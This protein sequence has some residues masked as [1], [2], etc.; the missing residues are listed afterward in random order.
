MR[1]NGK[2]YVLRTPVK[3]ALGVLIAGAALWGMSSLLS[4]GKETIKT[5]ETY[6]T[7]VLDPGHGGSDPGAVADDGTQE[8]QLC[9]TM[10]KELAAAVQELDPGIAVQY[11]WTDA[12]K[13]NEDVTQNLIDR[14]E[15]GKGGDYYLSIH[16]NSFLPEYEGYS[17]YINDGDTFWSAVYKNFSTA[18]NESGLMD[19]EGLKTMADSPLYVVQEN[20]IPSILLEVG[21]LTN[22]KDLE[23]LTNQET[24]QVFIDNLAQ[25]IVNQIQKDNARGE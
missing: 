14:V 15:A 2:K 24:R 20:P 9:L 7:L 21:Y 12:D 19:N 17:G 25:A 23:V 4:S 6:S 22:E 5:V 3:L 8:D 10:A 13:L 11:T 18:M 16:A 1:I